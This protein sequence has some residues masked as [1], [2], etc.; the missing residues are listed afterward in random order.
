MK[1]KT[2]FVTNSSSTC[3]VVM[4][5]GEILLEDF[6]KAVGVKPDSRFYDIYVKLFQLCSSR[7]EKYYDNIPGYYFSDEN[8]ERIRKAIEDGYEVYVGE[9][10]SDEDPVEIY[11]CCSQFLIKGDNFIIDG[12]T[13]VW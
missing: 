11:F 3:F 6:I 10:H 9:L 13:D 12:T 8:K 2:D 4:R 7:M 5:K 1:I